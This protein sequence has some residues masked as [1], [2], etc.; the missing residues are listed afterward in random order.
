LGYT[1]ITEQ[2]D[3]PGVPV[4]YVDSTYP[5]AGTAVPIGATVKLYVSK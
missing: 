3:A 1:V 4:G 5:A 2:V